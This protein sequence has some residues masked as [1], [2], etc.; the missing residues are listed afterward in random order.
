[1]DVATLVAQMNE[2]LASI[3]ATIEGLSTSA[4]E[5]DTKLDE[6]EQKR[7]MTLAELKAAYE[8]EQ[9]ELAA[10]RQKELD[11]IAEQRR[12][13]DE[14]REA[15][16]RREDEELAARKA[17][18]DEEKKGTFD[19]TTRN[20]E[21]EMD[22]L[23]DSIEEETAKKIAQGEAKL[24]ELE[25]KRRELNRL[26]EEQMKAAVPPIP[27]RK[28]AR[29]VRNSSAVPSAEPSPLP[30]AE[31][32]AEHAAGNKGVEDQDSIPGE[33]TAEEGLE[34]DD[35]R[36]HPEEPVAE[37]NVEEGAST[38]GTQPGEDSGETPPTETVSP[39]E[40]AKD[41]TSPREPAVEAD[42]PAEAS[43][44]EAEAESTPAE[45]TNQETAPDDVGDRSSVLN[46]EN[47]KEDVPDEAEEKIAKVPDTALAEENSVSQSE[48]P[49]TTSRGATAE[50]P[51]AE[52]PLTEE[53]PTGEPAPD[54]IPSEDILTAEEASAIEETPALEATAASETPAGEATEEEAPA[55]E[56]TPA[57]EA[58][59]AEETS[60]EAPSD[61]GILKESPES[62]EASVLE[63][64][65]SDD[66]GKE[67][68]PV[69]ENATAHEPAETVE[70]PGEQPA[71]E[72]TA[73]E[74]SEEQNADQRIDASPEP[75]PVSE[76]E[77][78]PMVVREQATGKDADETVGEDSTPELSIRAVADAEQVVGEAQPE[79][80]D[81][82]AEAHLGDAHDV[83]DIVFT[84]VAEES[85][86]TASP[87]EEAPLQDE[88]DTA[89]RS[90]V[91]DESP[92]E[93]G[94]AYQERTQ[95]EDDTVTLEASSA[96][97]TE[98]L[99]EAENNALRETAKET[100]ALATEDAV[101]AQEYNQQEEAEASLEQQA[102]EDVTVQDEVFSSQD[103]A[104]E[105][106]SE[107]PDESQL[108][109]D[110]PQAETPNEPES[111]AEDTAF[112][113]EDS[114]HDEAP[115]A[116]AQGPEDS[117][118]SEETLAPKTPVDE[119]TLEQEPL[120]AEESPA[121]D[122][123]PGED[124]VEVKEVTNAQD[125][126][127]DED[128]TEA[129]AEDP[130]QGEASIEENTEVTAADGSYK[131][132][133]GTENA[134][135]TTASE[136]IDTREVE[137]AK[138]ESVSEKPDPEDDEASPNEDVPP[139]LTAETDEAQEEEDV[140]EEASQD[141]AVDGLSKEIVDQEKAPSDSAT[142]AQLDAPEGQVEVNEPAQTAQEEGEAV[143]YQEDGDQTDD[144]DGSAL[145]D[146]Q[147]EVKQ[148]QLPRSEDNEDQEN[149]S[150]S[151]PAGHQ[152]EEKSPS[153]EHVKHPPSAMTPLFET[154][155]QD[156]ETSATA[157]FHDEAASPLT[158]VHEE[159]FNEFRKDQDGVTN[160]IVNEETIK[161]EVDDAQEYEFKMS[162]DED[163]INDRSHVDEYHQ[164]DDHGAALKE[165]P[166]REVDVTLDPTQPE[167]HHAEVGVVASYHQDASFDDA[168][169]LSEPDIDTSAITE[170]TEPDAP[171]VD[172][173][174]GEASIVE[175]YFH[176]ESVSRDISADP[177]ATLDSSYMAEPLS[178]AADQSYELDQHHDSF[179]PNSSVHDHHEDS[180]HFASRQVLFDEEEGNGSS[181]ARSV[182][183]DSDVD[184][185]SEDS[186][187]PF[188]RARATSFEQPAYQPSDNIPY[189]PFA[190]QTVIEEETP[191]ES[192]NPFARRGTVDVDDEVSEASYNPFTRNTTTSAAAD[193]F[194]RSASALG[195]SQPSSPEQTFA[196]SASAQGRR[197]DSVSS[198]NPFARSMKPDD[199]K[200]L[201]ST[202]AASTRGQHE[203]AT[204]SSNNPFARNASAQGYYEPDDADTESE[205]D[206]E[207][208]LAAAE[209]TYKNLFP[210]GHGS[211]NANNGFVS[212]APGIERRQ[213]TPQVPDS[214][215]NNP[216]A[217]RR[218]DDV[219]EARFHR[220]L[221]S[222]PA[223]GH[224]YYTYSDADAEGLDGETSPV[225]HHFVQESSPISAR[226]LAPTNLE[227][228][229]ERYNS[230]LEDMD[231]ESE[232]PES[233]ATSQQ[234]P[235]RPQSRGVVPAMPSIAERSH[236]DFDG[237][238][239]EGGDWDPQAHA[240]R[241]S[242]QIDASLASSEYRPP[243]PP[244]RP[245]RVPNSQDVYSQDIYSQEEAGDSSE[246][247]G[248]IF[249][250]NP[251]PSAH[252]STFS[253]SQYNA[254]PH[255]EQQQAEDSLEE[256]TDGW[257]DAL[258]AVQPN[259]RPTAQLE[260]TEVP[261]PPPPR[262]APG[263][264]GFHHHHHHQEQPDSSE[265]DEAP[266]SQNIARPGQFPFSSS[267]SSSQFRAASPPT[268]PLG[269]A[270]SQVQDR[271]DFEGG[272]EG[273][274][275]AWDSNATRPGQI[276]TL[277]T[278]QY[279]ETPPPPPPPPR[280]LRAPSAQDRHHQDPRDSDS[281]DENEEAWEAN[282][283]GQT[284]DMMGASSLMGNNRME[285][286]TG[287]SS[288]PPG[289]D[290][291]IASSPP[292]MPPPPSSSANPMMPDSP[293]LPPDIPARSAF[294]ESALATSSQGLQSR[295]REEDGGESDDSWENIGQRGEANAVGI[296]DSN[297]INDDNDN[298]T[299]GQ[300]S[301]NAAAP[302]LR[303]DSY[304]Q[305]W[306]NG[307][308]DQ[309]STASTMLQP[310]GPGDFTDTESQGYVTPL[311]S[312]GFSA[313]SQYTQA[314]TDSPRHPD[315]GGMKDVYDQSYNRGAASSPYDQDISTVSYGHASSLAEEL[316]RDDDEDD[317][318]D[319]EYD[320]EYDHTQAPAF[321]TQIGTAQQQHEQ[322]QLQ[323]QLESNEPV[324]EQV[325]DSF[326]SDDDDDDDEGPKTAVI[327]TDGQPLQYASARFGATSWR[328]EL[329]SPTL[330]G[331][332]R[333]SRSGSLREE[334]QRSLHQDAEASHPSP[335]QSAYQLQAQPQPEEQRQDSD[336]EQPSQV[337]HQEPFGQQA[338]Q[339]HGQETS[340]GQQPSSQV[341]SHQAPEPEVQVT[342]VE[343]EEEH[344]QT[345]PQLAPQ[346]EHAPDISPLALQQESPATPS[347]SRGLA[348]SRHNPDRPQTP[349]AQPAPEE[350]EEAIDP[351]LMIP[352]DVTN[353]PW[354]ART[355]S[356]PHSMRSQSTIDSI[357]S[358]PVHSALHA[359]K[360]EPVIRDSWP[361]SVQHL[362]RP[363]NDSALSTDR[364]RDDYDPFRFEGA[365]TAKQLV[366]AGAGAMRAPSGSIGSSSDSPPRN[367][368][369]NGS[370]GSLISR[371]RG[372]FEN[373]AQA[374]QEPPTSPVRS[375]PVSG[376][377]HSVRRG[378]TKPGGE[379]GDGDGVGVGVGVG[380]GPGT[381][382]GSNPAYGRK[383]GFLNEAED[384]A[385]EKSALLRSSTG[386]LEAN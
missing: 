277:S 360:H 6:L 175:A 351:E 380:V 182:E 239:E 108:A 69:E 33:G 333:H 382:T 237:S 149:Q 255:H 35:S 97:P 233:L 134:V 267:V 80:N 179:L 336:E 186:Y 281:G 349:P 11:D 53:T 274:E 194:L 141:A 91:A 192:H 221:S 257:D 165:S 264:Q 155:E 293:V 124:E 249:R 248:D 374:K 247:D 339:T 325:V 244:T 234:L 258:T 15:R 253:P 139:D 241:T 161:T 39:E 47:H 338:V 285:V 164:H 171:S 37:K 356:V 52:E 262:A 49:E 384:E 135:E 340:F 354:H 1:M 63:R 98:P 243:P 252:P 27:T 327:S 232:G 137:L 366:G 385:D 159:D 199:Q 107:N 110:T 246:D 112:V 5:S 377:F 106:G 178:M 170:I 180:E 167:S 373:A 297:N 189:N 99:E 369:S 203:A 67:D 251:A 77:N 136:T 113:Q 359:D 54:A 29:T 311:P 282:T 302:Q 81:E 260:A 60:K 358:S 279:R 231:S 235:G 177:D 68:V 212:A 288:T 14:E 283:Y 292:P 362:T 202:T 312:A 355:D 307:S 291:M 305:R 130:V 321:L 3:H 341:Q 334:F 326:H 100:D 310:S 229:Q 119:V 195:H 370:P 118:L 71:E 8:K 200:N 183:A 372:I 157:P 332:T 18:E 7:D 46:T 240:P 213:P 276:P 379:V 190:L 226:H 308:N 184:E 78:T 361:A 45:D 218:G 254:A 204:H 103:A 64:G 85:G 84:P 205:T 181:P 210:A 48:T 24:A 114:S 331:A 357:A 116:D 228:I 278:S 92:V 345:T 269:Y 158:Q 144:A 56:D 133:A 38:E 79:T 50:E 55:T 367:T 70:E 122:E 31:T 289:S 156:A 162:A 238:D 16:R 365:A 26:I 102:P 132:E 94:A 206:D 169:R 314:A 142:Q 217:S 342:E 145:P 30:P 322:Q 272:S 304:E 154:E 294:R 74:P 19:T 220:G 268:Q 214:M 32:L 323:Q 376:V 197:R 227:S 265:D 287:I 188:A 115:A 275:D 318:D 290:P 223:G 57:E 209:A 104:A 256:E 324:L 66:G 230:E 83:P 168:D 328:D 300:T 303:V 59:E 58:P 125:T 126:S 4:A 216:F 309:I 127:K 20:V 51:V 43:E 225:A 368:A 224:D 2:A 348:F 250:S 313:S 41:E 111:L 123:I 286:D 93:D 9:Q 76:D 353:V 337:Y 73:V 317:N 17:K 75:S 301:S 347:P 21:D 295:P 207:E 140:T 13:E 131:E 284:T 319:S 120:D 383:A 196:R 42:T 343:A 82:Q 378:S 12:R 266:H 40:P 96:E 245:S 62:V 299:A 153:E 150:L 273:G 90:P 101:L 335:L 330:F 146:S 320:S 174:S 138:A 222:S 86:E 23:M 381:G 65:A 151:E 193:N 271:Q 166:S 121:Q 28:R 172:E 95:L 375:R 109:D 201:W 270:I 215:Y 72:T 259:P 364:D 10:A 198:N 117:P 176:P 352:R 89:A 242:S 61:D 36:P 316:A 386:G 219:D 173:S 236:R 315:S 346:S 296:D 88:D 152:P 263:S 147:D 185:P 87:Q 160:S 298:T 261:H 44:P 163:D 25:E 211:P 34:G 148:M 143:R 350:E 363:R 187:N 191:Q 306:P 344:E 371:M 280:R 329:R 129:E 22:D 208:A 105:K 128:S